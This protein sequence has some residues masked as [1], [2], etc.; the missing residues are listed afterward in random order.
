MKKR[1]LLVLLAVLLL[2]VTACSKSVSEITENDDYVD[3]TVSVKGT[4]EG[5][6]KIGD[7][8]GYT[9]VDANGDKIIVASERLPADGDK[10]TA[11]GTLKK[12]LFGL[13]FY[14]DTK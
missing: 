11:K 8:S 13:G 4:A 1:L 10:V 6:T 2:T 12:G 7:L 9:L 3:K 5:V 14:I